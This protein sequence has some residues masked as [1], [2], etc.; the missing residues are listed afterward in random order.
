MKLRKEEVTCL[1]SQC[2]SLVE[3]ER[4]FEADSQHLL[5]PTG[6]KS[7]LIKSNVGLLSHHKLP[8]IYGLFPISAFSLEL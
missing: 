2:D 7:F 5:I 1:Q 3:A 8:A 6:D 4:E